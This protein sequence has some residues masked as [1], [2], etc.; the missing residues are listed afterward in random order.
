VVNILYSEPEIFFPTFG[1]L[2]T[3]SRKAA[4]LERIRIMENLSEK[5][6]AIYSTVTAAAAAQQESH[7]LDVE[8][9]IVQSVNSAVDAAMARTVDAA[10]R[11][12]VN[13]ATADMRTYADGV[14]ST[15]QQGLGA[16]RAQLGLAAQA[17][18][19][20]P[21]SRTAAGDAE[22][23]PDGHR[24]NPTTR[25]QGVVAS[26]LYVPPPAR[27]NRQNHSHTNTPRSFDLDDDTADNHYHTRMPR[28]DVPRFDGEN[29]KLWQLQCEDYFEMY[30]TSPH[31]W[32][33]LASLQFSGP[34]AHWLS[35]V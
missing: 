9:L 3:R 8:A 32:V 33:R 23:G 18:E 28:M 6:R 1:V 2:E 20:D 7:K 10:I 19:P 31:L 16:L 27:G 12:C 30:N 35:S 24:T 15:L 14:E 13:K 21:L 26:G 4:E 34:A 22:T 29:P 5:G 11:S 25:R 17:D